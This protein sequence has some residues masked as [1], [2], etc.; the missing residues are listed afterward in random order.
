[1]LDWFTCMMHL[2]CSC[3]R[4]VTCPSQEGLRASRVAGWIKNWKN[5]NW[6]S[7]YF[8]CCPMWP[9]AFCYVCASPTSSYRIKWNL[10]H[11]SNLHADVPVLVQISLLQN[12]SFKVLNRPSRFWELP[13]N[14]FWLSCIRFLNRNQFYQCH[15]WYSR[16]W[17]PL[18]WYR[19]LPRWQHML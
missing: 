7:L 6:G 11:I 15:Y 18:H 12:N 4:D 13:L 5:M 14:P 17:R 2:C 9:H 19:S 8:Q 3:C 10:K 16:Q 1:M